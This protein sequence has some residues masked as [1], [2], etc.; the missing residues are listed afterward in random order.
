MDYI[1]VPRAKSVL[2]S[3]GSIEQTVQAS[4]VVVTVLKSIICDFDTSC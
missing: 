4:V 1:K 3:L 2:A